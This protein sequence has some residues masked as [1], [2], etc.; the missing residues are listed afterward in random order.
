[1]KKFIILILVL[2]T[3]NAKLFGQVPLSYSEVI[4]VNDVS[5]NEL[6]DRAKLWFAISFK[7]SN[8]VLQIENKEEGE[9]VG[10]GF[11]KYY[12]NIWSV[13]HVTEG[14]IRF[15]IKI[16]IKDGRYKYEIN[17]FIHDPYPVTTPGGALSVGFIT[18]SVEYS[19][20]LGL[21]DSK[22]LYN[23]VWKDVKSEIDIKIVAI[24][25][26]LKEEMMKKTESK[27]NDW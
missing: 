26:N 12:S 8:S 6:F 4:Q 16:Y 25:N 27:K 5:K 13:K 3:I 1:M 24:V 2:I 20:P 10:K 14:P 19:K 23:R 11:F 17:D 22:S 18:T 7:S 9:L 21:L 15:T